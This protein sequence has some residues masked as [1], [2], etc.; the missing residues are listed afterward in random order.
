MGST[1]WHETTFNIHLRRLLW[2]NCPGHAQVMG[3]D[4]ADR[5]VGKETT[6]SSLCL[7]R[8][9]ALRSLRH[10]LKAQSQGHHTV[11]CLEQWEEPGLER[12]SAQ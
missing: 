4:Q 3:N 8:S 1:N 12:G 2:M 6:I 10:Y 5:L 7:R 9:E 11:Y